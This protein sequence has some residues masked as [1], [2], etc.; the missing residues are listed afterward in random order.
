[1]DT[2]NKIDTLDEALRVIFLESAKEADTI[3]PE[4]E[5]SRILSSVDVIMTESNKELLLEKLNAVIL[6]LSFGQLLQQTMNNM[7]LSEDITAEKS[8]LPVSIIQ[9]LKDDAIYTN[10]VPIKLFKNLLSLLN[11]SFK[12]VEGSVRKTFEI[13]QSQ[14]SVKTESFSG[15]SPAF[16][17]GY[18][19]SRESLAKNS[20]STDGKELFENK[21][22]LEKYLVRLNELMNS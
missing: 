20:P 4:K 8:N 10:N 16:R 5:M 12:L 6:S 7:G 1:M 2:P 13:L 14:A 17:K 3:N 15:F 18:Y 9:G 21:E 19:A 22:A 11:I